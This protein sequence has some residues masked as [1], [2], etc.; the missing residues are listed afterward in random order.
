MAKRKAS[1]ELVAEA[2]LTTSEG[3]AET[4]IINRNQEEDST[5][6]LWTG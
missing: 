1:S 5:D 6:Q 3:E 4:V 2:T